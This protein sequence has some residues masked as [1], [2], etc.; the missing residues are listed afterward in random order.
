MTLDA[1]TKVT[2]CSDTGGS[3]HCHY[4]KGD[5]YCKASLYL[6]DFPYPLSHFNFVIGNCL[7]FSYYFIKLSCCFLSYFCTNTSLMVVSLSDFWCA[8]FYVYVCV[9]FFFFLRF[10]KLL[11]DAF[12]FRMYWDKDP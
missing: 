7:L 5:N 12:M 10:F 3:V 1:G 6:L 8:C 2:I 9:F 11:I 4:G